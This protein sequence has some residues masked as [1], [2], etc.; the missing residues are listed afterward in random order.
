MNESVIEYLTIGHSYDPFIFKHL[1]ELKF[2]R[3]KDVNLEMIKQAFENYFNKYNGKRVG[4]MLS[5][6]K[7]SRLLVEIC[8]KL[9]IDTTGLTVGYREDMRENLIAERVCSK[10]GISHIFLPI[11]RKVY[12]WD[13]MKKA[14]GYA[15]G[16]IS[17]S[18]SF[19]FAHDE[20]ILKLF[21]V[22]FDGSYV[23]DTLREDRFYRGSPMD[24]IMSVITQDDIVKKQD[25][26]YISDRLIGMYSG[27]SLEE[28]AAMYINNTF[29]KLADTTK[30]LFNFECPVFDNSLLN[31]LWSI[32]ERD[33]VLRLLKRYYP[34]TFNIPGLRSI[35]PIGYPWQ[36]HYG[37]R[38][39]RNVFYNF[40]NG[41]DGG[42][43]SFGDSGAWC[44]YENIYHNWFCD[45]LKE[46]LDM[47]EKIS[48]LD[49]KRIREKIS[50]PNNRKHVVSFRRLIN[51]V[52]WMEQNKEK[53]I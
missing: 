41:I 22:V 9:G 36:L 20:N 15:R 25:R 14:M 42:S 7:D 18:P 21:D 28:V 31:I 34:K 3:Q 13:N 51:L 6:G 32:P 52:L 27:L 43:L 17:V 37:Y 26:N 10:L 8:C 11:S 30:D 48:F 50:Q 46:H 29:L 47:L 53:T 44:G 40:K 19:G 39:F 24:R 33:N 5:A 12:S 4:V 45:I 23:T 2:E 1:K 35:F 16:D 38:A 49:M